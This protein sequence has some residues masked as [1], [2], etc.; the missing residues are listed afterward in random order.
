MSLSLNDPSVSAKLQPRF[1]TVHAS[2]LRIDNKVDLGGSE[3]QGDW[4]SGLAAQLTTHEEALAGHE[5][6]LD[7][8]DGNLSDLQSRA[9]ALEGVTATHNDEIDE[10]QGDVSQLQ[11]N[12]S[13]QT[14]RIT[15]ALTNTASLGIRTTNLENFQNYVET[16]AIPEL[17]RDILTNSTSIVGQQ[18]Q[19]GALNTWKTFITDDAIPTLESG[20]EANSASIVGQQGQIGTLNSWKT[21][22]TD[23]AIPELQ[24]DIENNYR[25]TQ[26]NSSAITTLQTSVGSLQTSTGSNTTSIGALNTAVNAQAGQ[27]TTLQGYVPARQVATYTVPSALLPVTVKDI[28]SGFPI[29]PTQNITLKTNTRYCIYFAMMSNTTVPSQTTFARIYLRGGT[30]ETHRCT[31]SASFVSW[32]NT[33]TF[34]TDST[35]TLYEVRMQC[36]NNSATVTYVIT[37]ATFAIYELP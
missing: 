11:Q 5:A 25:A 36:A 19:I 35:N 14:G 22:I 2:E 3:V 6:A 23:D 9:Q 30:T 21:F 34:M 8:H 26:A 20:I 27:I 7:G 13:T 17:N 10:L 24:M 33:T 1:Y 15:T 28:Q 29:G 12:L 37:G 31:A 18:G 4:A 16:D 32:G